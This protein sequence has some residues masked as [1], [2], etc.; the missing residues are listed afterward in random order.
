[1]YIYIIYIYIYYIS[2]SISLPIYLYIVIVCD[3]EITHTSYAICRDQIYIKLYDSFLWMRCNCLK[4]R[5]S[6]YEKI[7]YFLPEI[8]G[9]RQINIGKMKAEMTLQP[10]SGFEL[11]YQPSYYQI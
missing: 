10:S 1:M 6:H 2:I 7:V 3:H 5:Q 9:T 8:L 11:V 4:A